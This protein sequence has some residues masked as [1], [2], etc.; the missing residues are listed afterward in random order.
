MLDDEMEAAASFC[1]NG[2][3]Q[4]TLTFPE[5]VGSLQ[6]QGFEGY[7]I[8]FRC[9]LAT[10]YTPDGRS[11]S[12]ATHVVKTPVAAALDAV[13][14]QAAIREAQQL[15]AGY[16]YLGFCEKAA[17]AGCAGYFVSFSGK[18][19]LYIGRDAG[20]HEERFPD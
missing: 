11:V 2:A 4:N 18:R 16:T 6:R 14:L 19:V 17:A 8:N 1:L 3:Q 10:Y 15:V 12:L 7:T 20:V 9:S 5:I 13:T